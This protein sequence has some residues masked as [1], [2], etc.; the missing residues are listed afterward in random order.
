MP[1]FL[2]L[3]RGLNVGGG[4][5]VKMEALRAMHAALGHRGV[6]TYI[7]SGNVAFAAEGDA[8]SVAREAAA[9]FRE[10]FGFAA[11]VLVVEASRWGAIVEANPYPGPAAEDPKTVHVAL[12]DG[13]PDADALRALLAKAGGREAFAVAGDAIY[14]HAPDG[15]GRSRFAAGLEKAAGVPITMRN[16]R[17]AE[18]LRAL[19]DAVSPPPA[20]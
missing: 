13:P 2:A 18:A 8:P 6:A 9:A 1:A 12:C 3:Y 4:T 7:Q 17:T 16:W 5:S 19:A 14:L 15:V 11:H 10:A 20:G